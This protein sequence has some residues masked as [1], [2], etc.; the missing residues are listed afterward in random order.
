MLGVRGLRCHAPSGLYLLVFP[1]DVFAVFLRRAVLLV[2]NFFSHGPDRVWKTI[3][4]FAWVMSLAV[5]SVCLVSIIAS[6]VKSSVWL[7]SIYFGLLASF[8]LSAYRVEGFGTDGFF[9][10]ND[11][12]V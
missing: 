8:S 3:A 1:L 11:R 12:E 4:S 2:P 9:K 10:Q 7:R 6:S 5:I